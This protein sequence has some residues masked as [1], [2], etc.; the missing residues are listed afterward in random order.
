MS[1]FGREERLPVN[2]P[3]LMEQVSV[4]ATGSFCVKGSPVGIGERVTLERHTALSLEA[5]HK[6]R[7]V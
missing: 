3:R 2:N 7:L 4:I 5:L 1:L 6:C